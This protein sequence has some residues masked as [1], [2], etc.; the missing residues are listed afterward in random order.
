MLL[1]NRSGYITFITNCK[2]FLNIYSLI[3]IIF[4][5]VYS[6]K[7]NTIYMMN[8]MIKKKTEFFSLKKKKVTAAITKPPLFWRLAHQKR[9]SQFWK[10]CRGKSSAEVNWS[11]HPELLPN[12]PWLYIFYR[13]TADHNWLSI[14][15]FKRSSGCTLQFTS[16]ELLILHNF[17]NWECE[18]ITL[19]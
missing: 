13:C 10:F 8:Y 9:Q 3:W 4:E 6:L 15:V 17:Q 11:V 16:A 14:V 19:E 7:S 2:G 5:L 18:P 12:L 1:V